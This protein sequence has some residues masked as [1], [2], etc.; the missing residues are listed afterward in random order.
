MIKN[1][2]YSIFDNIYVSLPEIWLPDHKVENEDIL[3][4]IR[5]SF[6]GTD[7]E[8]ER[9]KKGIIKSFTTCGTKVRYIEKDVRGKTGW[10]AAEPSRRCLEKNGVAP[11]EI[12]IVIFGSITR[13]YYEP[14]VA[15]EVADLLGVECAHTFDI[16]GACTTFVEAMYIGATFLAANPEIKHVLVCSSELPSENIDFNIGSMGELR[17]KA[18][19]LTLGCGAVAILLSKNK[20]VNGFVL[21]SGESFA[22]PKN[23]SLCVTPVKGYLKADSLGLYETAKKYVPDAITEH[24]KKINWPKEAVK[25]VIIHQAGDFYTKMIAEAAELRVDQVMLAHQYY[26]NVGSATVILALAHYLSHNPLNRGDKV[27]LCAP[28]SGFSIASVAMESI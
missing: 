28:G 1:N 26:G 12:D 16:T 6:K 5:K 11:N 15:N 27:F 24:F 14:A 2:L 23:W 25:Q 22:I 19:A 18:S 3:A 8:Y 20:F 21:K 13:P 10:Y 4:E 9:L 7:D 17:T